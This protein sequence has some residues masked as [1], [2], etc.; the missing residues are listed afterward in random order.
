MDLIPPSVPRTVR[1]RYTAFCVTVCLGASIFVFGLLLSIAPG[2]NHFDVAVFQVALALFA[3][4]L[5]IGRCWRSLVPSTTRGLNAEWRPGLMT[6]SVLLVCAAIS[7]VE[8]H[9]ISK[10]LSQMDAW[11]KAHYH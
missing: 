11:F 1:F 6:V 4:A 7:A 10:W 8:I 2:T 5:V 9:S 3:L